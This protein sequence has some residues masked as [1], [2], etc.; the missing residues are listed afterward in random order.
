M[1]FCKTL[2]IIF[3][4]IQTLLINGESVSFKV[5]AVNGTPHVTIDGQQYDMAVDEYPLYTTKVDISNFP[6]NYN[7]GI[8]YDDGSSEEEGFTRQRDKSDMSLNEFFNRSYTV[9]EH[10]QVPKAY[11][12][13]EFYN[14]SKLFDDNYVSTIVI[15]VDDQLLQQMYQ[16]PENQELKA[17]AVVVYASPYSVRTFN[18]AELSISG[19]STRG[20]PKLSYKIKNLKTDTN[21]EL[22]NRSSI[23][24][25]AEHMDPSFIRDKIYGDILNSLGVPAAQN[26]FTRVFI[27]GQ[28]V[29]L[30]DLSDDISNGRYLRETFNKGEKYTQENPIFKADYCPDC[31]IG[32]VYGDLGYYVKIS[33]ELIPLVKEINAYGNGQASSMSL[34]IDTFLKYMA[35]EFLAGGIDNYWNKPGNFFI[36]KD[37]A[38]GKWYFHDADFH[39]SFGV[40]G[41]PDLM[42]NT[43]LSQYPPDLDPKVSRARPPLDAIL[44]HPENKA[45]FTQI[46]DRLLKTSFHT[47]VLF[48]RI[49][50]LVTL[51]SEDVQW[52]FTLPRVSQSADHD[53]NLVYTYDD[54]LQHVTST[55]GVGRFETVPLKYFISTK[56]NLVANELGIQVPNQYESDLGMVENPSQKASVNSLSGTP[57]TISLTI[58]SSFMLLFLTYILF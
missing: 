42:L 57:K 58:F 3:A 24:L 47:S 11:E 29:G 15:T 48:P 51:I 5:L 19:Q 1:K 12:P 4:S 6:V 49:D 2:T 33:N 43:P 56:I 55:E 20:V 45:K 18:N 13:F 14:P 37:T 41:E 39:F 23:K 25:R 53:T 52:D 46:F 16:N 40:G 10:S 34:D 32:A 35:V 54:F 50:S 17:S 7:Y 44:S 21:K 31:E 26:K 27:N 30:F 28:P 36:F 22:F 38:K 8:V 9:I